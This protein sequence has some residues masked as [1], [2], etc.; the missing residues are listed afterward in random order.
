MLQGNKL[1]VKVSAYGVTGNVHA[2]DAAVRLPRDSLTGSLLSCKET[3]GEAALKPKPK[4]R[5]PEPQC[6]IDTAVRLPRD[7]L[8]GSLLSCKETLGEALPLRS[9]HCWQDLGFSVR[10]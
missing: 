6:A 2:M 1:S 9:R 5:N 4:S 3:L 10:V 8:T 7:S